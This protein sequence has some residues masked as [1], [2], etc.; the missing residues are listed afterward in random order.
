MMRRSLG[1]A[2]FA[3]LSLCV[4]GGA[5]VPTA[6]AADGAVVVSGGTVF[7]FIDVEHDRGECDLG[8]VGNPDISDVTAFPCSTVPIPTSLFFTGP[9]ACTIILVES[10]NPVATV[11]INVH[12]VIQVPS[13]VVYEST[14]GTIVVHPAFLPNVG[15][16]TV[17][18]A[19][20]PAERN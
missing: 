14:K 18:T 5:A 7:C 10:V 15:P 19:H 1:A 16:V 6:G 11:D 9:F 20:C 13:G 12:C 8:V 2:V 17:I 3:A 4:F